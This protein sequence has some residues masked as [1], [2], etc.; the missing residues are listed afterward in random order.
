MFKKNYCS[1]KK[2]MEKISPVKLPFWETVRRSFLYVLANFDSCVRI[3]AIWFLILIYEG[4]Y[5]FPSVCGMAGGNCPDGKLQNISV[6][7]VSLASIAV[8]VA[9]SRHVILKT[10]YKLG[11]FSFGRREI[12]YLGYSMVLLLLIFVPSIL[13]M[14]LISAILN[15][16]GIT[17]M[18]MVVTIIPLAAAVICARF[19]IILPAVAVDDREMTLRLA[20]E[21]TKGNANKIFWGQALIMLPVIIGFMILS[22][23]YDFFGLEGFAADLAVAFLLLALSF[24]DACLKASYYSHIYQYFVYFRNHP[25]VQP[26]P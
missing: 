4:F 25:E 18:P 22:F 23:G 24:F 1:E 2:T 11:G 15:L 6:I 8:S 26:K 9:F 14:V 12:K 13:A 19:F 7:M 21:L 3:S 16:I 17:T 5:G 10:K 20:F